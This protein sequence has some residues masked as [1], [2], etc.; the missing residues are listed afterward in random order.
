MFRQREL[1][2]HRAVD[3][4]RH[5]VGG[6]LRVGE[7][8][9]V[10]V[11]GGRRHLGDAAIGLG[12]GVGVGL[13]RIDPRR[14]G[15]VEVV[16]GGVGDLAGALHA[17][18]VGLEVV[19]E[20]DGEHVDHAGAGEALRQVHV[21]AVGRPG[22]LAVVVDRGQPVVDLRVVDD[23]LVVLGGCV[24]AVGRLRCEEVE[25]ARIGRHD[26]AGDAIDHPGGEVR[27]VDREGVRDLEVVGVGDV[28]H[29]HAGGAADGSDGEAVDHRPSPAERGVGRGGLHHQRPIPVEEHLDR[30]RAALVVGLRQRDAAAARHRSVDVDVDEPVVH[31]G[32]DPV[33]V[34][35][36]DVG[37]VDPRFLHV[38]AG[39]RRLGRSGRALQGDVAVEG[40]GGGRAEVPRD[41]R[42][43]AVAVQPV[44]ADVRAD[45][46]LDPLQH[47]VAAVRLLEQGD[48]AG[49]RAPRSHPTGTA[50]GQ[51]RSRTPEP[52]QEVASTATRAA[53]V[54][55]R[56]RI[57][58]LTHDRV[59]LVP[60]S[61]R[62]SSQAPQVR[63]RRSGCHRWVLL[64]LAPAQP[65]D[66]PDGSLAHLVGVDGVDVSGA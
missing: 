10:H 3:P 57:P 46:V 55:R 35:L 38:G 8:E 41:R 32:E 65:R 61:I 40:V 49:G 47:G 2:H 18:G 24:L 31:Q 25:L 60:V 43:V 9:A 62:P 26:D 56:K 22:L 39:V 66:L 12:I 19:G 52:E 13:G 16:L 29:R 50:P 34:G 33:A 36:D 23:R 15:D 37:L 45:R 59:G 17:H 28:D 7:R 4:A 54:S 64:R 27:A 30:G 44:R 1:A 11:G 20:R 6:G 21:V 63:L 53:A 14:R 58:G 51:L 48:R 42:A 5:L